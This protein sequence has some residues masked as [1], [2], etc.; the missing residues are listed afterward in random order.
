[1]L[2]GTQELLPEVYTVIV[3]KGVPDFKGVERTGKRVD[4]LPFPLLSSVKL[5]DLKG[6]TVYT[7]RCQFVGVLCV[8]VQLFSKVLQKLKNTTRRRDLIHVLT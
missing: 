4:A 2:H 5:S 1:M 8:Y 3:G 6:D 7:K